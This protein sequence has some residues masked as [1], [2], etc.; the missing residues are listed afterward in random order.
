[1][2][3]SPAVPLTLAAKRF[4][5]GLAPYLPPGAILLP[6]AP[7]GAAMDGRGAGV[8]CSRRTGESGRGSDILGRLPCGLGARPGPTDWLNLGSDGVGGV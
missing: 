8:I 6:F 2:A 5:V 1:L 4:C 3:G 7:A